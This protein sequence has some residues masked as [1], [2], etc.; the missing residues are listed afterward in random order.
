MKERL[1]AAILNLSCHQSQLAELAARMTNERASD[2]TTMWALAL[3]VADAMR[4]DIEELE[5]A[6]AEASQKAGA[7]S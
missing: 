3:T 2:T 7:S 6:V 1:D 4:K 5:A